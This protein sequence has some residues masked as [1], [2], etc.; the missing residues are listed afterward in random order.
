MLCGTVLGAKRG[1]LAV[2]LFL[3]LTL[4]GLPLLSGGRGGLG[5]L[6]SPT[7]G[8]LI[9]FPVAAYVTGAVTTHLKANIGLAA[10]LGFGSAAPAID[11]LATPIQRNATTGLVWGVSRRLARRFWVGHARA[12]KPWGRLLA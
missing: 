11:P 1:A 7:V 8:Y 2:L 3:G 10:G 6:A 9:G 12:L 4:A 5:L